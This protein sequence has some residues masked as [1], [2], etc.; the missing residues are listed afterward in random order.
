[1]KKPLLVWLSGLCLLLISCSALS[2]TKERA[3]LKT[4]PV[5]IYQ[6]MLRFVEKQDYEK[7]EMSLSF[8]KPVTA[9]I[10]S[11]WDVDMKEMIHGS[12]V[13]RDKDMIRR[14]VQKLI[15]LDMASLLYEGIDEDRPPKK[16]KVQIRTAYLNYLLLSSTVKERKF[17]A[18][19]GIRKIFR[20]LHASTGKSLYARSSPDVD[21]KVMENRIHAIEEEFIK[22]F[23]EWKLQKFLRKER[24]EHIDSEE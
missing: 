15:F 18:D 6:S 8:I 20:G 4:P 19:Q 7:I 22:L 11:R 10:K 21:L 17:L 5:E 3:R 14:S 16:R 9:A 23:P 24:D 13:G 2:N 1:M 12:V